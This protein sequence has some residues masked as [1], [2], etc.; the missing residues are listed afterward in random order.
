MARKPTQKRA[1]ATYER[2]LDAAGVLL[3]E[4]GVERIS[5]NLVA[6]RAGVSPPTLYNY[7]SDKYDLLAA[8]GARL[9]EQQNAL[10]LL[11]PEQDEA[12]L[13]ESLVEHVRVTL[14]H[15]GGPWV[16][17]ML[18]A[19]PQLAK[20]RLASH[21]AVSSQLAETL[22]ERDPSLGRATAERRARLA[23]EFGYAAIEM[24]FDEDGQDTDAIMRDTAR[25]IRA[26][27]GFTALEQPCRMN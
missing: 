24:V 20:V 7:F 10:V 22:L 4:L 17:R 27:L 18:R 2:L 3:E 12:A 1:I 21:H 15:P 9:M 25:T 14:A 19:V 26:L 8:L 11:D 23:V 6:E 5:T 13:A 16:M